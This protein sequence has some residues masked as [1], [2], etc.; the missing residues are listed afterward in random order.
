MDRYIPVILSAFPETILSIFSQQKRTG[1]PGVGFPYR[2]LHST[3]VSYVARLG[4]RLTL[5]VRRANAPL[6]KGILIFG[7][8]KA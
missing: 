4:P 6:K 2:L 5:K 3:Q 8:A 7:G 1:I